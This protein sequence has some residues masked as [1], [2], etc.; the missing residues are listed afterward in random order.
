MNLPYH[1][2]LL[3]VIT[4]VS[5]E[6]QNRTSYFKLDTGCYQ[7]TRLFGQKKK[8][9]EFTVTKMRVLHSENTLYYAFKARHIDAKYNNIGFVNLES[10]KKEGFITYVG[11]ELNAF[12]LKS[13]TFDIDQHQC[14]VYIGGENGIFTYDEFGI[15]K[16]YGAHGDKITSLSIADFLYFKKE[17]DSNIYRLDE[18][19]YNVVLNN[20]SVNDFV[21]VNNDFVLFLNEEGLFVFDGEKTNHV[22]GPSLKGFALNLY[23]EVFMWHNNEIYKFDI[24]NKLDFHVVTVGRLSP[25]IRIDAMAFDEND[26]II[27]IQNTKLFMLTHAISHLCG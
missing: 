2:P 3:L 1:L 13:F 14:V 7:L 19:I 4:L 15:I 27:F 18:N 26:N 11:N 20:Q 25:G 6:K 23:D 22:D 17:G 10:P 16:P 12:A 21:V 5:S 24:D 8:F 9:D